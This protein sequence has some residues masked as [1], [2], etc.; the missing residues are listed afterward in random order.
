MAL[1]L[2]ARMKALA[3]PETR[4]RLA[5]GAQHAGLI[6]FVS[7]WP[8]VLVDE[9]FEAENEKHRGRTI[10][11]IA[12][13]RGVSPF[14]ALLD[15]ALSEGLRTSFLP[16]AAGDDDASWKLRAELWNDDRLLLGASDAG[17]HLDMIDTF[18]Y[19]TTLLGECVRE[20]GLMSLETAVA[21]LTDRP[22]RLLGLRDRGRI[23]VGGC[24]DLVLLDPD[25]VG[26]G[27]IHTRY[28]LPA[29]AGRLYAESTGIEHVFVGGVA[30]VA[31]GELTQARP[32]RVLRSGRDTETVTNASLREGRTNARTNSRNEAETA[33]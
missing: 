9:T 19:S 3:D 31:H 13:E 17:A 5:E 2:D 6:S 18:T 33:R 24:A 14:Y 7:D 29:G 11:E 8:N 4:E 23:E 30:L 27:E 10:G 26:P 12:S 28:D 22:A 21:H 1:P 20:R 32:G 15:L 25:T 16:R